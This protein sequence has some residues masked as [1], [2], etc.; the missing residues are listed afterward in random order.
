MVKPSAGLFLISGEL[1]NVSCYQGLILLDRQTHKTSSKVIDSPISISI[2]SVVL[3]AL[4]LLIMF[5]SLIAVLSLTV[6]GGVA[7]AE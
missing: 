4:S 5:F 1:T 2:S 3:T 7:C 6:K